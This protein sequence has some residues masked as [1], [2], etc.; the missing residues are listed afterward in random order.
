MPP[1]CAAFEIQS[2]YLSQDQ[3]YASS[4]RFHTPR[5]LIAFYFP[6]GAT[7]DMGPSAI[8]PGSAYTSLDHTDRSLDLINDSIEDYQ[9]RPGTIE[10]KTRHV[11]RQARAGLFQPETVR[12]YTFL[13]LLRLFPTCLTLGRLA[14][15]IRTGLFQISCEVC[16]TL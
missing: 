2:G 4:V 10:A 1:C 15:V 5:W 6:R 3:V 11:L 12:P 14:F 7:N 16:R 13:V 8:M 9:L